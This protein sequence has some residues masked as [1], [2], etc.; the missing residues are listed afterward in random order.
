ML[1]PK[2]TGEH[3]A[4]AMIQHLEITKTRVELH[5]DDGSFRIRSRGG[6]PHSMLYYV[7]QTYANAP[8]I[9]TAM[10]SFAV[11]CIVFQHFGAT[12][13]LCQKWFQYNVARWIAQ[14][15]ITKK[16]FRKAM[17]SFGD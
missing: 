16:R 11:L 10:V 7:D 8:D 4:K 2:L 1:Q 12:E 3:V 6:A 17:K 14:H 5:E 15:G 13:D 9:E